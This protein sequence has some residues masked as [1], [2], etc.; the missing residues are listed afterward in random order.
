[1][2]VLCE[3]GVS[4]QVDHR[5]ITKIWQY[6]QNFELYQPF[7]H[8]FLSQTKAKFLLYIL[9][10]NYPNYLTG[11]ILCHYLSPTHLFLT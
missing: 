7:I 9:V 5:K 4:P 8:D 1:M 10:T 2:K 3:L 11:T 6:S